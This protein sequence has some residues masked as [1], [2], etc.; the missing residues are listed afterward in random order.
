MG[1]VC[2]PYLP[3]DLEWKQPKA[4][5]LLAIGSCGGENISF[6][7]G[8][9]APRVST[10]FWG[11]AIHPSGWTAQIV[12]DRSLEKQENRIQSCVGKEGETELGEGDEY[13]QSTFYEI[14]REL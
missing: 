1:N 14:L 12:L 5:E 2:V 8:C 9:V 3:L 4:K 7:K 6:R 13:C 10:T 11:K